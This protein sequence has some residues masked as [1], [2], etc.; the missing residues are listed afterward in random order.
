MPILTEGISYSKSISVLVQ[1]I[2]I[3]ILI[4][5]LA[6]TFAVY[7]KMDLKL[8]EEQQSKEGKSQCDLQKRKNSGKSISLIFS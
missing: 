5:F 7:Y 3:A 4:L 2:T 1:F 6:T 8:K